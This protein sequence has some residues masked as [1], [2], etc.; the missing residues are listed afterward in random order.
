MAGHPAE[1][2]NEFQ[3][4]SYISKPGENFSN[5]RVFVMG[6]FKATAISTAPIPRSNE[7]HSRV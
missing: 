5:Q 3:V 6:F 7:R 1:K 4:N 2:D